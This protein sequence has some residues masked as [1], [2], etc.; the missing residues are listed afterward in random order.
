MFLYSTFIPVG[1]LWVLRFHPTS[2]TFQIGH[3]LLS[4]WSGLNFFTII[5][6]C[7]IIEMLYC[8]SRVES[9]SLYILIFKK[10]R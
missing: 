6:I 4:D 8:R 3:F 5:N 1:F 7:Y 2:E 9:L 10:A